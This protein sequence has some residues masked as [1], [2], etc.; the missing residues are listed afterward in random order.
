[1]PPPGDDVRVRMLLPPS[2]TEQVIDQRLDPLAT[3]RGDLPDHPPLPE[4]RTRGGMLRG[5]PEC[6]PQITGEPS[7]LPPPP[8]RAVPRAAGSPR[9]RAADP[10]NAGRWH[11]ASPPPG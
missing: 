2:G 3:R 9:H 6:V 8:H 1:M 4:H 7:G 5:P 11:S 10:R